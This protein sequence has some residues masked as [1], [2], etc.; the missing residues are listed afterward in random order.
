LIQSF[1]FTRKISDLFVY[2]MIVQHEPA[3]S[4]SDLLDIIGPAPTVSQVAQFLRE[5]STTTW[6]RLRDGQFRAV[7]GPGTTRIS[8]ESLLAY[9][10][11]SQDY[12]LTHKRGKLPGEKRA[13]T[14][15]A[16]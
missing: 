5:S 2:N 9:L 16:E 10:N 11:A 4:K 12:Q 6:R 14:R 13:K 7:P 8:L 3:F 15:K 1:R